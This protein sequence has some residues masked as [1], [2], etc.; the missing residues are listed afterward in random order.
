MDGANIIRSRDCLF[1]FRGNI[2]NVYRPMTTGILLSDGCDII[3]LFDSS[4]PPILRH[5]FRIL[6][7]PDCVHVFS[8]VSSWNPLLDELSSCYHFNSRVVSIIVWIFGICLLSIVTTLLIEKIIDPWISLVKRKLWIWEIYRVI[9][10]TLPN[11]YQIF[12]ST[13][14][15]LWKR[16]SNLFILIRGIL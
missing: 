15:T 12:Y 13:N 3:C 6:I 2:I 8:T 4:T 5:A 7:A 9:I 1:V 10:V 11:S 14:I 16:E